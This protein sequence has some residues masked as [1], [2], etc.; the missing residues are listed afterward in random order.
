[1]TMP[2]GQVDVSERFAKMAPQS[3]LC[4]QS[5]EH[6]VCERFEVVSDGGDVESRGRTREHRK[7]SGKRTA[8]RRVG[9]H[10]AGCHG[11]KCIHKIDEDRLE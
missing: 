3:H 2:T 1:M 8:Q 7:P 6:L 9:R 10:G 5:G 11:P 4:A